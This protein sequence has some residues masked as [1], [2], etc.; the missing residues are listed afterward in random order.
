M[1]HALR[2]IEELD[3]RALEVT[4]HLPPSDMAVVVGFLE[5]M[6]RV[7]GRDIESAEPARRSA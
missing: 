5:Q 7:V 3:A 4:E 6:A 1:R 2:V